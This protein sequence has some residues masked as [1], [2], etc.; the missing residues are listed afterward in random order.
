M[1]EEQ[2][3]EGGEGKWDRCYSPTCAEMPSLSILV[4]EEAGSKKSGEGQAEGECGAAN[5]QVDGPRRAAQRA[6]HSPPLGTKRPFPL[7]AEAGR[8]ATPARV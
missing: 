4:Q 7:A 2:V 1:N 6:G 3:L 8:A 5:Y